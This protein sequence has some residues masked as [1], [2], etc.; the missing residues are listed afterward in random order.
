MKLLA[1]NLVA[2][3]NI[4]TDEDLTLY[5]LNGLGQEYDPVVVNATARTVTPSIKEVYSLL[6]SHESRMEQYNATGTIEL[7]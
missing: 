5:I 1:D 7:G 2:A 4:V 3:G 6:L